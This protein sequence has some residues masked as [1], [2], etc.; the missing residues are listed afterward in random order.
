MLTIEVEHKAT[1]HR[2]D[3]DTIQHGKEVKIVIYD[4]NNKIEAILRIPT[5]D[6]VKLVSVHARESITF[7]LA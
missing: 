6:Q 1:D 3:F 5:G 2:I 7:S 4:R